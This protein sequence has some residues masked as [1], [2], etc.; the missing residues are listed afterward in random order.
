MHLFV[1][2][3][4]GGSLLRRDDKTLAT[5]LSDPEGPRPT[6]GQM[7]I[8]H[9][10]GTA[11]VHKNGEKYESDEKTQVKHLATM[12]PGVVFATHA[13]FE[14]RVG[15]N[16]VPTGLDLGI[17]LSKL[18]EC[19][20]LRMVSRLGYGRHG[21]PNDCTAA[22]APKYS[23]EPHQCIE[24]TV[25]LLAYKKFRLPV[26]TMTLEHCTDSALHKSQLGT[27]AFQRGDYELAATLYGRALAFVQPTR[28]SAT[29][30]MLETYVRVGTNLATCFAKLKRA[31]KEIIKLT[32]SIISVNEK[33]PKAWYQ[34]G[35]AY[36]RM[37]EFQL[38][39][40][41]L[42]TVVELDPS[43]VAARKEL[44]HV[45]TKI[46]LYKKKEKKRYASIFERSQREENEEEE[47]TREREKK[48]KEAQAPAL[49][50]NKVGE[51]DSSGL[52]QRK[53]MQEA[54]LRGAG[55]EETQPTSAVCKKG[56]Q[57]AKITGVVLGAVCV[58][59]T[60]MHWSSVQ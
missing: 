6:D 38:A 5:T 58:G 13:T 35:C 55:E 1:D 4:G 43:S 49:F 45:Q 20:T 22:D 54:Q 27:R 28:E 37:L 23:V 19:F 51:S 48:G 52:R 30:A 31:D 46:A 7:V 44:K 24:Y 40:S 57:V 14:F 18:G 10:V 16:E 29:T 53:N 3:L 34:M 50:E 36:S 59:L 26:E 11:L 9:L 60:W 39:T 17:R 32:Q 33:S 42:N 15:E 47:Q 12:V 56:T 2:V 41:C 25:H 8:V 21:L